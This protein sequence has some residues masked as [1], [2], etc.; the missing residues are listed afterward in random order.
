MSVCTIH[1]KIAID[2]IV[3]VIFLLDIFIQMHSAF[4]VGNHSVSARAPQGC[5]LPS[6][7]WSVL[8]LTLS[9]KISARHSPRMRRIHCRTPYAMRQGK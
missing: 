5:L 7:S 3:N 2:V 1:W 8:A 4:F 6:T 9:K